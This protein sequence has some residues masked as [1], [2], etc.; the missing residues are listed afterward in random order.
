M[1]LHKLEMNA[2]CTAQRSQLNFLVRWSFKLVTK[3]SLKKMILESD[4]MN[5]IEHIKHFDPSLQ[6]SHF[7][8]QTAHG[9]SYT[10]WGNVNQFLNLSKPV[11]TG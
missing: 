2:K 6:Q 8:R 11:Y 5:R 4:Y 1:L 7:C 9:L 10:E 3:Q